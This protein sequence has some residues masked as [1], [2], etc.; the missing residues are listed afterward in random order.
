MFPNPA[1]IQNI[2]TVEIIIIC[3]VALLLFGRRLPEVARNLGKGISEFKRGIHEAS[4]EVKTEI[5]KAA[6]LTEAES[7]AH[8]NAAPSAGKPE[9]K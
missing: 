2:G 6:D 5:E 1:F 4:A 7:K 8:R 3:I 9:E